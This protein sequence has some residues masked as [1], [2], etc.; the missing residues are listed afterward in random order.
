MIRLSCRIKTLFNAIF[1]TFIAKLLI[2]ILSIERNCTIKN[3]SHH[4]IAIFDPL[5]FTQPYRNEFREFYHY[6][7]DRDAF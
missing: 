4:R 5:L 6:I 1:L 2:L 3:F 7:P